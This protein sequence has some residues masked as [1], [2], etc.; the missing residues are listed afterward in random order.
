MNHCDPNRM[1]DCM[2][3]MSL[4][5]YDSVF[6]ISFNYTV[7]TV[8]TGVHSKPSGSHPSERGSA[9]LKRL[10][11]AGLSRRRV[12]AEPR[13]GVDTVRSLQNTAV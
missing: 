10:K 4:C 8:L 9:K 13:H 1:R 3:H 6:H 7:V 2:V 12:D 5:C 11:S